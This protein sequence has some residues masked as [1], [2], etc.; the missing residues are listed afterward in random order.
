MVV[1]E[2]MKFRMHYLR[3]FGQWLRPALA[4]GKAEASGTP[5]LSTVY[6]ARSRCKADF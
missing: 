2:V 5:L 4:S 3:K 6:F 1:G